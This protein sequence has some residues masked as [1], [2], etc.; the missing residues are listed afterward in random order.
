MGVKAEQKIERLRRGR[1]ASV[2]SIG[3]L[4]EFFGCR[5]DRKIRK[6]RAAVLSFGCWRWFLL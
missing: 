4:F 3:S 6:G 1:R 2:A 5:I